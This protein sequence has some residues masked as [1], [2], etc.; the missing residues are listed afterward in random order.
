MDF[1]T[2]TTF[3]MISDKGEFLGGAIAPGIKTSLES[4]VNNA[5]KLMRI[6]LNKPDN[7]IG[8]TT[9]ANMQAGTIYGF[10]GLVKYITQKMREESGFMEAKVIATGGLSELVTQ[11]DSNIIDVID[12]YLTLKGLKIIY[13]MN[14]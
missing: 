12:R 14:K 10:T 5:S 11:V 6:E 9:A 1:G 4:L 13:N 8:K 7:I 2:A 3:N